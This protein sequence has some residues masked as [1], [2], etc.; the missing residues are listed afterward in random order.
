MAKVKLKFCWGIMRKLY[1]TFQSPY[2]LSRASIL[3]HTTFLSVSLW[4]NLRKHLLFWICLCINSSLTK[5]IDSSSFLLKTTGASHCSQSQSHY[6]SLN[7][8]IMSVVGEETNSMLRWK[9]YCYCSPSYLKRENSVSLSAFCLSSFFLFSFFS[10]LRL[11]PQICRVWLTQISQKV[12][13]KSLKVTN[14]S[15]VSFGR[16]VTWFTAA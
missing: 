1:Q 2:S 8:S 5:S 16:K 6:V 12:L 11:L 4:S 9:L 15:I 10:L 3:F 13:T 7:H 14:M